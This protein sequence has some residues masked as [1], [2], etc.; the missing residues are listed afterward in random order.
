MPAPN[1]EPLPSF[2]RAPVTEVALSI[3]FAELAGFMAI[4]GGL[5]FQ[6]LR[7][8]YPRVAEH[9]PL[10]PVFENFDPI[11]PSMAQFRLEAFGGPPPPRF[12]FEAPDGSY[13]LQVQ[14]DRLVYNWRKRSEVQIYPRY[15]EIR[16]RF[17]REIERI[18]ALLAHAGL[19][20]LVPNQCEVTY[21][22]AITAPGDVNLHAHPER[23]VRLWSPPQPSGSQRR[24]F[25]GAVLNAR[26]LMRDELGTPCGR[27]YVNVMPSFMPSQTEPNSAAR[28]LYLE[29]TARG[30]PGADTVAGAFECLDGA[31]EAVVRT[32]ADVTTPEMHDLWER[33]DVLS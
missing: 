5:L 24:E 22:N 14:R 7:A 11:S 26:F 20:S 6:D 9:P 10:E 27:V 28:A 12:W 25:E 17:A 23:A 21:I 13:L 30:R 32:F 29:V 31:R 15:H 18:G 33:D 3:Q 4:H 8:D 2:G 19:G 16:V 1:P